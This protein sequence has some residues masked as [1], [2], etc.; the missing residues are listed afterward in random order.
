MLPAV[1]IVLVEI[2]VVIPQGLVVP[3]TDNKQACMLFF[4]MAH[5]SLD[6]HEYE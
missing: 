1:A 4:G 3:R 6:E 2:I 5:E